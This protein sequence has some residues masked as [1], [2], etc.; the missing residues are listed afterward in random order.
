MMSF[1]MKMVQNAYIVESLDEAC[2]QMHKLFGLGPFIIVRGIKLENHRYRGT[3]TD[4]VIVDA[5]V[6]QSGEQ[7]IELV[8]LKNDVPNAM[9][10]M[11]PG[12]G[13][14][15]HHVAHLDD[16]YDYK[17]IRDELVA[18]G[19]PVASEFNI[20]GGTDVCLVDTRP[21]FGHMLQLYSDIPFEQAMYKRAREI[22]DAWDGKDVIVEW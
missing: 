6:A 18:A 10:D 8:E 2:N 11:Y 15:M 4:D 20:H 19:Y 13:V 14:V 3:K 22:T 7:Q 21:L 12:K 17:K 1:G 5:A 16:D 9:R